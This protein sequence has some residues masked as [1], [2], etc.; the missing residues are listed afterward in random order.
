MAEAIAQ[1]VLELIE[2]E[3]AVEQEKE[4]ESPIQKSGFDMDLNDGGFDGDMDD[5]ELATVVTAT[6]V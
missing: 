3:K 2:K 6:E 4:N 1:H 5:N